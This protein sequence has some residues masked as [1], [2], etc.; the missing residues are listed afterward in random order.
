MNGHRASE[1]NQNHW[2]WFGI[3][4]IRCWLKPEKDEQSPEDRTLGKLQHLNGEEPWASRGDQRDEK[5][6]R[7]QWYVLKSDCVTSLLCGHLGSYWI[8]PCHWH[9][10]LWYLR[11]CQLR[12]H[13]FVFLPNR[14]LICLALYPLLMESRETGPISSSRDQS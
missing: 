1:G 7:R 5:K 6:T 11:S 12:I 3:A 14:I 9:A 13:P 2:C 10:Y 4:S 8:K